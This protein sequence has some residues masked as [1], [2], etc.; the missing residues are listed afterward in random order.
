MGE[1]S[2]AGV[3]VPPGGGG[4]M[5]RAFDKKTGKI[6]WEMELPGGASNSPMT[7]MHNKSGTS[8]PPRPGVS[9]PVS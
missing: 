7:Y 8:S 2:D 3:G 1:G 6:V 5:F 9:I 4:R